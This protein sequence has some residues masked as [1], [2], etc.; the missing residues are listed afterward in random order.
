MKK[1]LHKVSHIGKAPI[2]AAGRLR[3]VARRSTEQE[4]LSVIPRIT[5]ETLAMHRQE[6]LK[7][8]KKFIYPLQHSKH[9]VV[10]ISTGLGIVAVVT[11][12]VYLTLALYRFQHATDFL[13]RV[14]KAIPFP[15]AKVK[16]Q[17]VAYEN[18]LFELNHYKHY[19]E[20]QQKVD[21]ASES[22][23]QQLAEAKKQ[24]LQQVIDKAY[25]KSYAKEKNISVSKQEI[26]KQIAVLRDNSRLGGSN[27]VYVEV[28][29]SWYD[30]SEADF[31][32]QIADQLLA[33][34]LVA[35]LDKETAD[36]VAVA[37]QELGNGKD[38]GELA[39]T[40]ND[41]ATAKAVKGDIGFI[42]K[43]ARDVGPLTAEALYSLGAVN[44]YTKQ[45]I[46]LGYAKEIVK[47]TEEKDGKR[48]ASHILFY[49]KEINQFLNEY[50]D[51]NK[52]RQYVTLK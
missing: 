26:D 12:T 35:S 51:K 48:R 42:D 40:N 28:L 14:T 50:K 38:F 8:A 36:R 1:H 2:R 25:I 15:I 22:G 16:G 32:R 3:K 10:L 11:F 47:Y 39:A 41:D 27:K 30:W 19:Y 52:S 7:G 6:V 45:P 21:F 49:Y 9:K 29:R 37:Y 4:E 23:K 43:A 44:E 34:K 5:N 13:Y 17:Y 18:Y 46:E 31:E 24:L 33:Q 20:T